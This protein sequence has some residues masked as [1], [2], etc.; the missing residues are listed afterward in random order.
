M[1]KK[2]RKARIKHRKN[3]KRVKKLLQT[4]MLKVKPKKQIPSPLKEDV[5][6]KVIEKKSAVKK[7]T[8]KKT[9][10]KKK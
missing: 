5:Q 10:T 2:K 8:T 4:S 3:Q 9:T 7:T 1:N 6:S